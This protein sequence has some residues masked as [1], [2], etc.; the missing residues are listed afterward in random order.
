MEGLLPKKQ[1]EYDNLTVGFVKKWWIWRKWWIWWF[2][3]I[4]WIENIGDV[5]ALSNHGCLRSIRVDKMYFTSD[6]TIRKVAQTR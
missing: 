2:R 5:E 6:G 4:Q 3:W 1:Q